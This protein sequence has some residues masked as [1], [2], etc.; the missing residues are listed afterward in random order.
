MG[1]DRLQMPD[2]K[3]SIDAE[4]ECLEILTLMLNKNS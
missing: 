3:I 2:S 1:Q 4:I